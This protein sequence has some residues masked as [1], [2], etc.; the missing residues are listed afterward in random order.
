MYVENI[1]PRTWLFLLKPPDRVDSQKKKM[2]S[3]KIY[4][5]NAIMVQKNFQQN[6]EKRERA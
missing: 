3:E 4:E 1:C 5:K 2:R 6:T